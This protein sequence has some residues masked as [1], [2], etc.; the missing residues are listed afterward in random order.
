[1]SRRFVTIMMVL[2]IACLLGSAAMAQ[3]N[4]RGLDRKNLDTTVSPCDNFYEYANGS[5]LKN[6]PIPAAYSSW[7]VWH[8]MHERN[9]KMLHEILESAAKANATKGSPTQKIGDFF[10]AAMDTT[11]IE[12]AGATP[13]KA[14]LARIDALANTD[15]LIQLIT[16]YQAQGI[17]VLFDADPEAD[18]KNSEMVIL[19]AM[20]GGLGLPDRDYYTKTDDESKTIRDQ[21]VQHMVNM[22]KLLGKDEAAAKNEATAVLGLETKLAEASL[23]NV[24]LRDPAASYNIVTV[25]QADSLSPNF[26]WK[27]YLTGLGLENVTSFSYSHPKFFAEMNTLIKSAPLADWKAYI[28]WH[29]VSGA[30]PYLS[31]NLAHEDW[32]FF[33]ST[34]EGSKEMLP[35]WKRALSTTN[36]ALGEVLGQLFVERMFPPEAKARALEMIKNLQAALGKRIE[37]L[38]W[39][40]DATK[41][42]ALHKLSTFTPKIGYPDKWKD[43][44]KLEISRD[45]YLKNVRRGRAFARAFDLNKVGKPVDK[46]EWGMTPQTINAYYNPLQNEIVFP[47]AILQPPFF[48]PTADDALNYGAMG[49]I[50]GHE[51]TH[52]FDDQGSQFDAT[53]NM[54]NW[55]T[56]TDRK[57]FDEKTV[58]LANQYDKYTVA[59]DAH[60]NGKLTLGENIADLG[61]ILVAFEGFKMALAAKPYA[62][63]DGFTPEQRFFLSFAQAWR[64]NQRPESQK[65]QVNTDPHSPA[66]WRVDGTLTN[67]P[68]FAKAFGCAGGKTMVNTDSSLINIW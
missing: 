62:P 40:S 27:R 58:A 55:W 42:A 23:T 57:Q 12:A 25:A 31:S 47:A 46:T 14:D 10:Y 33:D 39:M 44:T 11:A 28:K 53:G 68:D 59:G 64:E 6:N 51:M 43:Y 61:G 49:A 50:I 19:Y 20:Q 13:L 7:G 5:W 67:V 38:S 21:Y 17:R 15:Q 34:L 45:S 35:R 2:T 54:V 41:Q 56:D 4:E 16:E 3:T 22:F 37:G 32:R 65:L 63:I 8:E 1:M 29:I 18:L 66:Y 36:R 52:G 24:E 60:V 30:A 9:S 26:S 48:D